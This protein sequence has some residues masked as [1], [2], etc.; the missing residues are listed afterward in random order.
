MISFCHLPGFPSASFL[1]KNQ[2]T[3]GFVFFMAIN[4][5]ILYS[6]ISKLA[7]HHGT[8]WLRNMIP[9]RCDKERRYRTGDRKRQRRRVFVSREESLPNWMF[10]CQTFQAFAIPCIV[11]LSKFLFPYPRPFGLRYFQVCVPYG[12]R[13]LHDRNRYS[14]G[15]WG[16]P[17]NNHKI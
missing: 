5:K 11:P 13:V 10:L 17:L 12:I 8:L 14:F 6:G 16:F 7:A 15:L 3:F 1:A 4:F 9:P 2:S